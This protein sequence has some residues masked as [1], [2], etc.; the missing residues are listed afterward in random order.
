MSG[1]FRTPDG[2]RLEAR[3]GLA[4]A[5]VVMLLSLLTV[6]C[7]KTQSADTRVA[8]PPSEARAPDTA[9]SLDPFM[10][11]RRA[12]ALG[13]QQRFTESLAHFRRALAA[14]TDAWQPHCDYA[15]TLFHAA[16]EPRLTRHGER[17]MV[18]TSF[19][20]SEMMLESA[21]E[22]DVAERLAPTPE[23]R[24]YVIARRAR[25]LAAWQL[26]WNAVSEYTRAAAAIPRLEREAAALLATMRDPVRPST[27]EDPP[28][29]AE[30]RST[31]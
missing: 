15:I 20:R 5:L 18:R 28:D 16:L 4:P 10:A 6:S 19:E 24:A 23:A 21:R 27:G 14:P 26:T 31:R 25:Q 2:L 17:T 9:S 29:L 12:L 3:W 11:Y 22:L 8:P 13:E 7:G 30:P 1:G